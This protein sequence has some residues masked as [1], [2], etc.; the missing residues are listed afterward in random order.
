M[1]IDPTPPVIEPLALRS[2][3]AARASG[4]SLRTFQSL[5]AA[6]TIPSL[7]VGRIRLVPVAALR[8]WLTAQTEKGAQQ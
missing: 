8:A 5:L 7:K 3:D 1:A 4:V 6:G 2:V